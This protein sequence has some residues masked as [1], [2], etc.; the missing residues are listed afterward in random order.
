[1]DSFRRSAWIGFVFYFFQGIVPSYAAS[2]PAASPAGNAAGLK[3]A[4]KI[5]TAAPPLSFRLDTRFER[6]FPFQNARATIDEG[7]GRIF[8]ALFRDNQVQV[9]DMKTGATRQTFL[10][11]DRPEWVSFDPGHNALLVA[12]GDSRQFE[13]IPDLDS[14]KEFRQPTGLNPVWV[15]GTSNNGYF[16]LAGGVH[17]LYRLDRVSY[18]S[19]D[20]VAL[21][22]NVHDVALDA[23]GK[24][25][26]LPLM[27]K[28]K[29]WI[30]DLA[31]LRLHRELDLDTC[32]GPRKV[33]PVSIEKKDRL[34]VLCKNGLY[35]VHPDVSISHRIWKFHRRPGSMASLVCGNLLIVSFPEKNE[36]DIWDIAGRRIV[37]RISLESRP[38]FLTS[39]SDGMGF[40]VITNSARGQ[41]TRLISY[42]ISVSVPHSKT[43]ST[44]PAP[45]LPAQPSNGKERIPIKR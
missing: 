26:Y 41:E 34:A 1:L 4:R 10:N 12:L 27:R 28:G 16:L 3:E 9:L 40:L 31:T 14:N 32:D 22:D 17:I 13:V 45:V 39:T 35:L 29:V 6:V 23:S 44:S 42:R 19:T 36:L 33:V 24:Q 20:W 11:L 15:G 8:L 43:V 25:I 5:G 7:K 2:P 21:G 37:K 30:V 38:I 18:A